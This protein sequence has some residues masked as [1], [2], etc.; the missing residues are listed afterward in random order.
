MARAHVPSAQREAPAL[1]RPTILVSAAAGD[2]KL[3]GQL[4]QALQARGYV[5]RRAPLPNTPAW[6]EAHEDYT[7]LLLLLSP[8]AA[9]ETALP[10]YREAVRRNVAIL[11]MLARKTS[12]LPPE[13][14]ELHWIDYTAS[15]EWGWSGLLVAL[16]RL[17]LAAQE[18]GYP[19]RFD[20]ELALAR[21]QQGLTP[22]TW[23]VYRAGPVYHARARSAVF[24][25]LLLL[26]LLGAP[27]LFGVLSLVADVLGAG[28]ITA[29]QIAIWALACLACGRLAVRAV[30]L[31]VQ[32]R[33]S[34]LRPELLVLT[35]AGFVVRRFSGTTMC[36]FADLVDLR[37]RE[38]RRPTA[39]FLR[40]LT[41]DGRWRSSSSALTLPRATLHGTSTPTTRSTRA[42]IVW[43]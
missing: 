39:I 4:E 12:H 13:L 41:R 10:A 30:Q 3:A 2:A 25:G 40:M 17:G 26:V 8:E 29:V 32:V 18:G 42:R 38:Q 37:M 34:K 16:N 21:A 5:T 23:R 43:R 1:Q 20:A 22:P 28:T 15:A 33:Q 14:E 7:A 35:P 24:V 6:A 36:Q 11:P 31:Q 9:I 19:P 27:L